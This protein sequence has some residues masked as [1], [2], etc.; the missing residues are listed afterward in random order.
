MNEK[1][2]TIDTLMGIDNIAENDEFLT[3][4]DL[5]GLAARWK[6]K[7]NI[8]RR[9]IQPVFAKK[10]AQTRKV[11]IQR[12]ARLTATKGQTLMFA[13]VKQLDVDTQRAISSGNVKFKDQ[14]YYVRR[15]ISAKSGMIDLIE[16]KIDKDPGVTNLEKGK[17]PSL[18]N[19]MLQRVE[20]NVADATDITTK[21][22]DL[23]PMT[24]AIDN[25]LYNG[26]VEL[27][28]G[29]RT[30]FKMPVNSF[31]NPDRKNPEGSKNGF[32]FSA[33]ELIKEAT[34]INLRLHLVGTIAAKGTPA[35]KY[36]IIEAKLI[37]DGIGSK[38]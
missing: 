5:E 29:N 35:E 14:V 9:R 28:I 18:V 30:I 27:L 21:T 10:Q 22:A 17:L 4:E 37:G 12:R 7:K 15:D 32:N 24:N 6:M 33:P 13:K 31:L 23:A 19:F 34:D 38:M 16:S 8:L 3:D 2:N 25:A 36:F 26:E 20:I 1:E 11:E